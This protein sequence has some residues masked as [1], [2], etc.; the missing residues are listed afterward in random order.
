MIRAVNPPQA[1]IPGISHGVV[2]ESGR[3]LFLSG[4]VPFG[5]E[6]VVGGNELTSQ[7]EQAFVNLR[8][9]LAAAG[10]TFANVARLTLYVR[11]YTPSL[12]PHIRE[13][14]DRWI[15]PGCPPA[16]ALIGVA[17]LFHPD[18]LVEVDAIAVLPPENAH[19][20]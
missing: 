9:T 10:A 3:I 11:D 5:P 16:S 15:N 20:G 18:V 6:G 2:V 12:L 17:S 19:P 8:A 1:V 7:L 14:R 13:V 4:H